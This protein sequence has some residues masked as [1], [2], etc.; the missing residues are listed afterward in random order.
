LSEWGSVSPFI[1]P[2]GGIGLEHAADFITHAAEH[3]HAL[4]LTA[5]GVRWIVKRPMVAVHLAGKHWAG[6]VGISAY[7]DHG[8]DLIG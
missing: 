3:F 2:A 8:L 1:A 4:L 7:S 5:G 6:L